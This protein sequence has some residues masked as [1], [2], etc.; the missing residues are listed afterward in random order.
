MGQQEACWE[1]L[2]EPQMGQRARS[3]TECLGEVQTE[4]LRKDRT[5]VGLQKD[6]VRTVA[7]RTGQQVWW[8][9]VGLQMG[10]K[11]PKRTGG[12]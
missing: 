10:L 11:G 4:E 9:L 1:P 6:P 12:H 3:Q 2:E 8:L 5:E 7:L